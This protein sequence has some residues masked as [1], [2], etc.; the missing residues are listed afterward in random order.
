MGAVLG[1]TDRISWGGC[2]PLCSKRVTLAPATVHKACLKHCLHQNRSQHE[3]WWQSGSR[4]K[5][6]PMSTSTLSAVTVKIEP[7]IKQRVQRLAK[8]RHRTPHWVMH[9]AIVQFVER[10]EKREAFLTGRDQ[11]LG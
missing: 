4:D 2:R 7:A 8:A 6:L 11:G 5:V 9:E 10:E 3:G 1:P